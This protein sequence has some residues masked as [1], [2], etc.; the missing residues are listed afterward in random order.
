[1]AVTTLR[2]HSPAAI[3]IAF[4]ESFGHDKVGLL[5]VSLR[6]LQQLLF[7]TALAALGVHRVRADGEFTEH[8]VAIGGKTGTV[9]GQAVI[10]DHLQLDRS[11]VGERRF[12]NEH[13]V[14]G[15]FAAGGQCGGKEAAIRLLLQFLHA[16]GTTA[17]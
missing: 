13:V 3:T 14:G 4:L 15:G 8:K 17:P 10:W 7:T 9:A 2:P 16:R 12:T 5:K 6:I 1:M 11:D